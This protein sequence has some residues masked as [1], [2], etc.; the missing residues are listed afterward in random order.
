M[1]NVFFDPLQNHLSVQ[2]KHTQH[3]KQSDQHSHAC[4]QSAPCRPIDSP[5]RI[6]FPL[7]HGNKSIGSPDTHHSIQY[8]LQYLRKGRLHH[9][10]MSLEKSPKHSQYP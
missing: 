7:H 8:L 3:K 4:S 5:C 1:H 9:R 6:R 2:Y 10:S